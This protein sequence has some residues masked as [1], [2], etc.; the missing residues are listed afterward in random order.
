ME[1]SY[2]AGCE[3]HYPEAYER[4]ILDALRGDPTLF[5]R[6][7]EVG[8]SWKI[9]DPILAHWAADERPIPLYQAATWGPRE[10]IDLLA[11]D[12][13]TWREL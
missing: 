1:F 11:R 5:I 8:R 2:G 9:V 13:R 3:E 12:G 10:A 6:G 4:V 7:D